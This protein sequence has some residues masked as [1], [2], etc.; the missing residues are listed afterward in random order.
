MRTRSIRLILALLM[1][2][3]AVTVDA[4]TDAQFSQYY[5]VPTFYNPA[6]IG[7]IDYIRVRG[8]ARLQWVGIDNAPQSFLGTADMPFKVLGKRF[9]VG[10]V[11][12]QESAGLYKSLNIGAQLGYKFK[13]FG[14]EFTVAAQVGIYSESFKGSEVYLPD[15]DDYHQS[16]D[17]GIPMQDIHGTALDLGVGL[18]YTHKKFWAGVS[19][20]HANSPTVTMNVESAT[21]G[22][23]T[24]SE[25]YEFQAN[26][27]LYFMTGSNIPLNNTLFEIVPSLLVKSD[28]TFWSGEINARVRYNKMF[29]GGVGYRWDDAIIISLAAEI[30]DFYIGYSYDYATSAIH[31]ATSGSHEVFAG[32]RFKLDFSDKNKNKQKSIRIM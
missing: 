9:G 4:Q 20:T 29:S 23:E 5:E 8:G 18:W 28:F 16:S 26:R 25:K 11:A 13:K 17:D 30:K 7:S 1:T 12:N 10:V 19:L 21:G 6:A 32:Y 24:S 14:G 3:T 2:L 27:T 22:S 31:S 15:D